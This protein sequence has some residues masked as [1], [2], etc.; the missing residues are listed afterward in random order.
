MRT[1]LPLILPLLILGACASPADNPGAPGLGA[2]RSPHSA[3]WP[4]ADQG[5]HG[6]FIRG[7]AR[8]V[9]VDQTAGGATLEY[10]GAV[11]RA[12]WQTEIT[13]AQGGTV[14][15]ADAFKPPVGQ[16]R[17]PDVRTQEF[18]AKPG[19]TI[20]FVGMRTGDSIFL[21]SVAVLAP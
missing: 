9:S 10:Q 15:Q 1:P 13:T 12:Y 5:E 16:Y 11:V 20:G 4:A 17:P 3:A 6:P 7:T 2:F 18:A 14:T 8:V 21:Q 19:D